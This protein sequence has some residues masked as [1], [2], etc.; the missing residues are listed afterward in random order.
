M[1][2]KVVFKNIYTGKYKCRI[3]G[4]IYN[5]EEGDKLRFISPGTP[6]E[7]LPDDWR[8]PVCKYSRA[9]FISLKEYMLNE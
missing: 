8:C 5:P 3:C 1:D 2:V 4:Y 9:Y 6:F 7:E